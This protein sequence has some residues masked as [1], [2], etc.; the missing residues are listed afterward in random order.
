[1]DTASNEDAEQEGRPH[2][3]EILYR[4]SQKLEVPSLMFRPEYIVSQ[5]EDSAGTHLLQLS[6]ARKA[7]VTDQASDKSR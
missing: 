6:Q 7:L 2:D 4:T 3:L 1:M 5:F